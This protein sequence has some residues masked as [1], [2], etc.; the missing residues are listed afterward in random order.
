MSI[1]ARKKTVALYIALAMSCLGVFTLLLALIPA[2]G[3]RNGLTLLEVGMVT[4][5]LGGFGLITDLPLAHM[6]RLYGDRIVVL[7]G[8]VLMA[9]AC[10]LLYYA[11]ID[12]R[13]WMNVSLLWA[14]A[15]VAAT[16]FSCMI[17]PLLGGIALHAQGAQVQVQ[18]VNAIAQR[19]GAFAAALFL[20]YLFASDDVSL[21][22]ILALAVCAGMVLLA[23][24][25]PAPMRVM[26][27]AIEDSG[28]FKLK[29]HLPLS[30][31]VKKAMLVSINTQFYMIAGYAFTPV[32]LENNGIGDA[33]GAS[34]ALREIVAVLSA[35]LIGTFFS[36]CSLPK[37]WATAA[38]VGLVSLTIVPII[39]DSWI[40]IPAFSAH[41]I[42]LGVGIIT[43][44]VHVYFGTTPK[45]RVYGFAYVMMSTRLAGLVVPVLLGGALGLSASV[46]SAV[47]FVSLALVLF[48]YL[49][50]DDK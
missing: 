35:A 24:T 1:T 41:G 29:G 3:L 36:R 4:S 32:I 39:S 18:A 30:S 20:G 27:D 34:L 46:F 19:I 42:A 14:S 22:P 33:F 45:T 25:L 13:H 23:R 11:A 17:A 15:V 12:V 49:I 5:M 6:S 10:V 28:Q 40:A 44:N 9:F 37:I 50:V 43:G 2:I 38:F 16:G 26:G 48:L 7:C 31:G 21:G 47:L 8:G